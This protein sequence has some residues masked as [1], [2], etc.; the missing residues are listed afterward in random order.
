MTLL[1]R[2]LALLLLLLLLAN[3]ASADETYSFDLPA[4]PLAATLNS[5][6]NTS[7]TKLIY[8]DEVVRNLQA[9]PLKGRFTLAQALDQVLNKNRLSYE[10]VDNSMI[11]IKQKTISPLRMPE[12]IVPGSID[13]NSP[14]NK[15]YIRSTTST[16]TRTNVSVMQTPFSIQVIP[17]QILKDQQAIRLDTVAQNV[18]G[19]TPTLFNGGGSDGFII[20]GF[21]TPSIFRNGVFQGDSFSKREMANIEQVDFLKGPGSIMF[22][23]TE[24]GGIVNIVTKQ[25]LA[26][27]YYSLQQQAGNFDFYRTTVDATGPIT[28][29]GA[30]LYRFN[31]AY[32]NS[33]SF[34]NFVN[35][36]SVFV[37]PVVRWNISPQTQ[38]T[39]ELEYS[40]Y[41][42]NV[43]SGIPQM[44]NKPSPLPRSFSMNDPTFNR[45]SGDRYFIG[46]NWSHQF[47][48]AWTI[49]HRLSAE[50]GNR[51]FQGMNYGIPTRD[52]SVDR[53]F[54]SD[55]VRTNRYQ[56]SVNL[57]GNISTGIL[58]HTLLFGYDYFFIDDKNRDLT[59]YSTLLQPFNIFHPVYANSSNELIGAGEL[60]P[61]F[62]FNQN[63]HGAYFQDQIKLPYN[64]HLLAG[65]RYDIVTGRDKVAN[66]AVPTDDRFSPRGGLLWQPM[67]WLSL[68][69][70]Y[71]ENFGATN[72]G[73]NID[74][75]KLPSQS[76]QQWELG[77]KTELFDGRLRAT[78][79]YFD[80]TKQNLS[81]PDPLNPFRSKA[82]GEA[83]TRG[84]EFDVAGEIF[85]GW[86]MIATYSYLPYAKITKDHGTIFDDQGN[87]IGTN[88]GTRG[89]RL[90]LAAKH[91]GSLWN[92]YEFR[93]ESLR[94]LKIG[95][96]IQ[97]LDKRQGDAANSY[98]LPFY[99][100][101]NLM[102]SYQ[103]N[104]KPYRVTAQL[105]VNNVSD[106][107]YF[108]A[109]DTTNFIY[110]GAPRTFL[111]SLRID[112]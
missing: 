47:N 24:P 50:L 9:A 52:G 96:G 46:V 38:I 30:L 91:T 85:P 21:Q 6:A 83:Q 109:S 8:A 39:A 82:I 58:Q 41:R 101:G 7:G 105:N 74:G 3:T 28:K 89:N 26:T 61:S 100:I 55:G 65:F 66:S 32:E 72:T 64:F 106:E 56:S 31:L 111:G 98:H 18:S 48:S 16:A 112:Y 88:D 44:D 92:I 76:A 43:D 71:T 95:G 35:H 15:H 77:A 10:L 45:L 97:G 13:A 42:N 36:N 87:A 40:N 49:N 108:A 54:F 70:N 93:N 34:R 17:Q 27:R 60:F 78:F 1:A 11:V 14:Y 104:V 73:F 12:I 62:K 53:S 2:S 99:V 37:A 90:F 51:F 69:G 19:V 33:G 86:N 23:R 57:I 25:P 4:Q 20:R 102:A 75:Q 59:G 81:T 79:S 107:T 103:F 110:Y 80:L 5:L 84:Y 63:W 68:Y 94:G 22:G 29:D 67:P